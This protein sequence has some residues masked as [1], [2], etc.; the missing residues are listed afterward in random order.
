[1]KPSEIQMT[2]DWYH[3]VTAVMMSPVPAASGRTM[4]TEPGPV[5]APLRV[6]ALRYFRRHHNDISLQLTDRPVDPG[7]DPRRPRGRRR[8]RS[9]PERSSLS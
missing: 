3:G 9:L 6:F 7:A 1:M 4:A 5:D 2:S 8:R